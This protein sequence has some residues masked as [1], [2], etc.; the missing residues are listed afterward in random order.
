MGRVLSRGVLRAGYADNRPAVTRVSPRLPSGAPIDVCV[1]NV[2]RARV[3]FYGDFAKAGD[4]GRA[5]G[6][7]APIDNI[8][9]VNIQLTFLNS[10]P[11]SVLSRV[12]AIF[13]RATIFRP[14]WVG[15]WTFWVLLGAL[16]LA[17]PGLLVRALWTAERKSGTSG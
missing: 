16:V 4:P 9:P 14:G 7:G 17:V 5:S 6:G 2:G 10:Q 13:R 3:A 11:S 8:G 12:P 1:R 15:S